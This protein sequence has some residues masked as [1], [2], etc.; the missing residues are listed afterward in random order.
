[1][2]GAS[3]DSV[4]VEQF[5]RRAIEEDEARATDPRSAAIIDQSEK[6]QPEDWERLHGAFRD[7]HREEMIPRASPGGLTRGS[8]VRLRASSRRTDA[9]DC[10]FVGCVATVEAVMTDVDGRAY[11]AVTLDQDPAA[12]LHRWYGR[13]QYYALDEVEPLVEAAEAAP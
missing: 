13:Y 6:L 10:L 5:V 11:V 9:Q 3:S 2:S 4:L 8:R 7:V 12:E 1:M